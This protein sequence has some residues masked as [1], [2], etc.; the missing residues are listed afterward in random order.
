[1]KRPALV[2]AAS[3]V[4][5]LL[6]LTA[7]SAEEHKPTVVDRRGEIIKVLDGAGVDSRRPRPLPDSS[8]GDAQPGSV[9]DGGGRGTEEPNASGACAPASERPGY[10]LR[11]SRGEGFT[12]DACGRVLWDP[13]LSPLERPAGPGT[14]EPTASSPAAGIVIDRMTTRGSW[15]GSTYTPGGTV[16]LLGSA[17]TYYL[18]NG[19]SWQSGAGS[20][21]GYSSG[22]DR[23]EVSGSTI[24]Y[25]LLAP[26]E[27]L[28]YQQTDYNSG[29]HSAQGSLGVSGPLVIEAKVGSSTAVMRGVARIV[30]NDATW[31]GEP[32][33]NYY[34]SIV[35][36]VVP[37]EQT[38]TIQGQIWA[39]DTFTHSFTYTNT[40]QVDFAHPVSVPRAVE[41]KIGGP[42]RVPDEST[43]QFAATVRYENGVL[44]SV[45]ENAGWSV[46]PAA[47]ASIQ[48]GLL[49]TGRLGTP[50]ETL[51][52]RATYTEGP[53][54][55]AAEK[56]VLCLA[57]GSVESPDA[58]AMYQANAQHTGYLPISLDP[59]QSG[60]RWQRDVGGAFALNPV[61]AADGKVFVSLL[62]Y[63]NDVPALF[64]LDARNGQPL[65]SKQFGSIFSVSPPSYS[66]GT[67]YV[68]TGNHATDTWLR[69]YD[70][71][72]GD[73]VFQA[74]H[75]A[76]WE[77][78]Y[79]PTIHEGKVYVDGGS[80][81][82]MYGF[83]AFSGSQ[84]WF[85]GLPQ[86]DQWT[87]AVAGGLAYAYVGSY[88]PGLYAV[89]RFTG[90]LVF[91]I[92][93]S[94]F[95]WDGWSMNL[96]PVVGRH[97]DVIAIHDGRL[98][99]FDI[100]RRSI[101]WQLQR[102]FQGQPSVA[103]DRIY[104]IDGGRLVVL[105]EVSNTELWSWPPPEGN[106][107]GPM[108]VTDTHL[109]GSTATNV[110]AVDIVTRQAVWSFPAAGLL[111]LANN[112]LYI[113]S[114]NGTLTA[115]NMPTYVP[116]PMVR[117]EVMGAAEVPENSSA[118]YWARVF[119]QDGRVWDRTL[120]SQWS[121][122]PGTYATFTPDGVMTT[123]ELLQPAQPVVVRARYAERGQT[124][125]GTMNV[126]LVIGVPIR[127]FIHRNLVR[128]IGI[129]EQLL[130]DLDTAM[131]RETAILEALPPTPR[132]EGI[133]V[134][135]TS[136]LS[137]EKD[138]A[139]GL[140][141]SIEELTRAISFQGRRR[142]P[143]RPKGPS[144][145]ATR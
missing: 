20:I 13:A 15:Y 12:V 64:A 145:G 110:Y 19:S 84:A 136:A 135:V 65:W 48:N 16:A 121:V 28:L 38:Y 101:R 26:P 132:N 133:R 32:R 97:D 109:L 134:L 83:D 126:R 43:V 141:L 31:Y 125:E 71:D 60:L 73:P 53:A 70:A 17:V 88:A 102:N 22:L 82:G 36:S 142:Q 116:S 2:A 34:A 115:V 131:V 122:E 49:T 68:Q 138:A 95:E 7:S 67:V 130:R 118:P 81:G 129:K 29:D 62:T 21:Y 123:T 98:I 42:S 14:K 139:S 103:Q 143:P 108:I 23:V 106:L 41:L 10:E 40:G 61:A 90:A 30:S 124:V 87:P 54:S 50:Q 25:V 128:S 63:F 35:G 66:F 104:A 59:E 96:A 45:T 76:Q 92:T 119:Y 57:D 112:T 51:T 80:Y 75:L 6:G 37:F 55:L 4:V 94:N 56:A 24:R 113:A 93:D 47:I 11:E 44:R 1:M 46:E 127:E 79:S 86:Y 72:T 69:A 111:A 107:T 33:F 9:P 85:R 99:S 5:S 77:R 3:L 91:V 58:W 27:G 89:D 78:Y 105:D 39:P 114:S 140:R 18:S 120:A 8:T 100:T 144:T 117:L 52:I 137:R 74:P